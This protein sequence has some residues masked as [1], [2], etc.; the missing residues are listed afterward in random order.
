MLVRGDLEGQGGEGA[1]ILRRA[2]GAGFLVFQDA[3]DGLHFRGIR[4]VVDHRV[5]HGLHAFVLEG[6]AA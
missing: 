6:G 3:F 5:E 1:V 2:G 4:Q